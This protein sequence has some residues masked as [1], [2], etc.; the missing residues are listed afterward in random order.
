[1]KTVNLKLLFSIICIS[2]V[3]LMLPFSV[4][5]AGADL[6]VDKIDS[7]NPGDIYE[8][9]LSLG[10]NPGISKMTISIIYDINFL[11]L[12]SVDFPSFLPNPDHKAGMNNSA[13]TVSF[14]SDTDITQDGVYFTLRFKLSEFATLKTYDI[15]ITYL[16]EDVCNASG[17]KVSLN[18]SKGG[19]TVSCRHNYQLK[20]KVEPSC[21]ARGY[22]EYVCTE[23]HNVYQTD[24]V[25]KLGHTLVSISTTEPTCYS[26]GE[27]KY[28]CSVCD[29]TIIES[30]PKTDHTY[31]SGVVT[32][33]THY[34]QGFTTYTCSECDY[35][36]CDNYTDI[37]PHSYTEQ[38]IVEPTCMNTGIKKYI[39]S[40]NHHYLEVIEQSGHIYES[41]VIEPTHYKEG[42]T[43]HKC[44]F[45][46]KVYADNYTDIIPHTYSETLI[47]PPSCTVSGIMA[48]RCE[49]G[50]YYE[51]TVPATG[52]S[53]TEW[54]DNMDGMR[55]RFCKNCSHTEKEELPKTSAVIS[56]T[57]P[58]GQDD[59]LSSKQKTVIAFSAVGFLMLLSFVVILV[60][61]RG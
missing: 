61:I 23:C 8:V 47:V 17:Q 15:D 28:K 24:F 45:C 22:T 48:H 37:V 43:L 4:S 42:Y 39:C 2:A 27:H 46:S 7:A 6:T 14:F 56:T 60:K 32:E 11:T 44:V 57:E 34:E 31:S 21:T 19:I 38:I 40:C 16:P 12:V 1:M 36:Y 50:A 58:S 25:E 53:F 49:C 52:H 59:T 5:A 41:S 30:I 51:D 26:Y 54:A 3:L 13:D 55:I 10:S 29:S 20:Q 33:P 9:N 35:S 18:V